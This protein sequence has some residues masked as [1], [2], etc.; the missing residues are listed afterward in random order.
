MQQV[1]TLVGT[2]LITNFLDDQKEQA[3]LIRKQ[4]ERYK[5]LPV[6]QYD[7]NKR[8][9]DQIKKRLQDFVEREP[10]ASAEISSL[11]RL[12]EERKETLRVYLLASDTVNSRMCAEVI[13]NGLQLENVEIAFNEHQHVISGLQVTNRQ[14]FEKDG[15]RNLFDVFEQITGGYYGHTLC[16]ITGGYKATIP[17]M[18]IF[19]QVN[20]MP[21]Y[22]L[23]EDSLELLKIPLLPISVD[24]ELFERYAEI[25]AAAEQHDWAID[26]WRRT[27]AL[28]LPEHRETFAAFVEQDGAY[29]LITMA[30]QMLWR[31]FKSR[32]RILYWNQ[33]VK[34]RYESDSN[35]KHHLL[36]LFSDH[37]GIEHKA[38]H[39]VLDAGGTLPR[40][41]YLWQHGELYV[42]K[43]FPTHNSE[44]ERFL[45]THPFNG[46]DAY[47]P[48][49]ITT[50]NL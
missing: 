33:E 20:R 19:A 2:S 13:R 6:S 25:F 3:A 34:A 37:R 41:F 15:L 50:I 32:R 30:G 21:L 38:G 39:L 46:L 12:S 40:I 8:D 31:K 27:E 22:Y 18:T 11:R 43:Y 4:V 1:L 10:E 45:D 16:N 36:K 24:W 29:A 7:V 47:G 28:I 49:E 35:A 9:I 26:D 17:L 23:Y 14:N 44:Y 5:P 48:Y 42:Y